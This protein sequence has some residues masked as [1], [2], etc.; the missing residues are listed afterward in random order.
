MLGTSGYTEYPALNIAND[1]FQKMLSQGLNW[2]WNRA[3]VNVANT[4]LGGVLTVALQQDYCTQTTNLGWLEQG[5]RIDINNSTNNGNLAPKPIFTMESVRDLGQT[6]YQANPFNVSFLPNSLAQMGVWQPNTAYSCGYGV[7]QIP[8]QPIQ[9]FVDANGNILFIDSTVLNLSINSPG[10]TSTPIVLPSP[11]PYGTSGSVQP[12]LPAASVAGTTVTDGTVTWTVAN[13]NG[14]AMRVAPL[15]AFSGLAWLIIPVYQ[16]KPPILT[17]LQDS[18]S[19]IPDECIYLFRQGFL[20]GCLQ[21]AKQ[22]EES[23][24]AY[25]QWQEDMMIFLKSGDRE[26]DDSIMYPSEG[27]SGGGSRT[28]FPIGAA[29]PFNYGGWF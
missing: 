16:K 1:I 18:L 13:P 12:V 11:N 14:Y 10:F 19:P 8:I 22:Y 3:Y 25:A 9:Q 5:W 2:K 4:G 15:P 24:E 23:R 26:R 28:P 20:A 7:A 17:S 29:N 27:I 6:A 21:H